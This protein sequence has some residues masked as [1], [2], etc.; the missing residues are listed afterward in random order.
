MFAYCCLFPK[1]YLFKKD[2]LVLLWMAEGFLLK[3][4]GS[5]S[6][7]ILGQDC[8]EELESRSFFQHSI[9]QKSQYT[10]HDLISD[11]ATSVAGE[12]FF[13]VGCKDGS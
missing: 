10:M 11:L 8:F 6:M 3:S 9:I 2:E 7:E 12:F 1:D 13:Y 4:N 5:K